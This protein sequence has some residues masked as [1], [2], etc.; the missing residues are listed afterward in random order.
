MAASHDEIFAAVKEGIVAV[1]GPRYKGDVPI[2][3]DTPLFAASA[4]SAP[5]LDL[6]SLD[7][8]DLVSILEQQYEKEIPAETDIEQLSTVGDI[9]GLVHETLVGT[10]Q[11]AQS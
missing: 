1:L 11:P 6:D 3:E 7:A 2:T 5:A 4:D 8:L 9:V 10:A